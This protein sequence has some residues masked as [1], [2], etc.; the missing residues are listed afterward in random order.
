MFFLSSRDLEVEIARRQK[1]EKKR[2]AAAAKAQAT[3]TAA[4]SAGSVFYCSNRGAPKCRHKQG[5]LRKGPRD[6]H[7]A[8]CLGRAP[9]APEQR[10]CVVQGLD[11]KKEE[12]REESLRAPPVR[13]APVTIGVKK[14]IVKRASVRFKRGWARKA[15][16]KQSNLTELQKMVM[17]RIFDVKP[18][19]SNDAGSRRF[20]AQF[21]DPAMHL[22]ETQIGT[23]IKWCLA[24]READPMAGKVAPVAPPAG[25]PA[26]A[27]PA[28]AAPAAGRGG[29]AAGRGSGRGAAR[30]RGRGGR[31][32]GRGARAPAAAPAEALPNCRKCKCAVAVYGCKGNRRGIAACRKPAQ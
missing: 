16:K 14:T 7:Q 6:T 20:N 15:K 3:R 22:S 8:K 27:A 12:K 5:F 30:G 28:A 11:Q 25:A 9:T 21:R 19:L 32:R 23:Q 26:A 2:V 24:K 31:G 29:A 18:N 17:W 1:R 4:E 10:P 13:R